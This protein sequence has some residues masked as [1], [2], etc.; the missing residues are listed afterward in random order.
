MF[1][2]V[3]LTIVFAWT[4][5]LGAQP[6]DALPGLSFAHHDWE[7]VCDNTRTCRAAGYSTDGEE[8]RVSV[9]LTR[10]AGPRTVITGQLL[11]G[12]YGDEDDALFSTLP[13]KIALSLRIDGRFIGPVNVPQDY[14]RADLPS[15]QVAALL[16]TARSDATIE[17]SSG[18]NTW[19]LSG[20]GAAAVLLKMD[21][22]QGRVG[23]QGAVISNGPQE[24]ADVLPALPAPVVGAAPLIEDRPGDAALGADE[25]LRSALRSA[26]GE[27]EEDRCEALDE[28]QGSAGAVS[29]AR[30]S[31]S[32]L[33]ASAVCWTGAYNDASGFWVVDDQAPFRAVLITDSGSDASGGE[34][35]SNQKGRGLGDCWSS[36]AFTWDGTEFHETS[37]STTGMCRLMAPGGAWSLPRIVTNPR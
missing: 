21:E 33:L 14:L 18:A 5:P 4:L 35:F 23:T 27:S 6:T 24:D 10:A 3:S 36:R 13:T 8:L 20:R 9:L 34:I 16:S 11:L 30:L 29:I 25:A 1:R 22:F 19:R 32:K 2:S 17:W 12:R 15:G 28:V 31:S 26:F 37:A 7:I